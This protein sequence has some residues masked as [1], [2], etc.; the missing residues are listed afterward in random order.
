M[1]MG[2]NTVFVQV[3]PAGDALY[4]SKLVPWSKYLTGKQGEHPGYDPLA[5]M[6]EETHR[7]GMAIHAW[8][9]PF[10]ASTDNKTEQ[11]ASNHAAVQHPEWIVTTAG[12]SGK[13]Y[14]NPGIP[15]VRQHIIDV[16]MEVVNGYDIDGVHLDDYFYPTDASFDDEATFRQYNA[17]K[18]K[19]KRTGV[20]IILMN[21]F[22]NLGEAIHAVKP[23]L[24]YGISPFGVWRNGKDDPSGSNTSASITA[25][26]DMSADTRAW[27]Q[28]GWIDYIMP[29]IYWS[30]S[31]AAA[32]YDTLVQWWAREV[33]GSSVK[34]YIG[35]APYKLGTK[36]AGWQSANEIID[37]LK[38]NE[39]IPQ[40]KG[41][42]FFSAKD[43]RRNPL[44]L[45][46]L[47]RDYYQVP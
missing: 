14:F 15:A 22:A 16:V 13:L 36:E 38:F 30:R 24:A 11:L 23:H 18:L 32:N 8:F 47:L 33:E 12:S 21:S 20:A 3:R 5:F 19:T 31:F 35:H 4:D 17:K 43:L 27:I 46:P 1:A 39:S 9:N 2:I 42:V 28:G 29:Q 6:V 41:D 34:L 26:D 7:R 37:Q 25:Y 40:V 10:R 45:V 44:D